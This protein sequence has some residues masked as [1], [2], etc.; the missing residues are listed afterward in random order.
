MILA[1]LNVARTPVM[2]EAPGLRPHALTGDRRGQWS[3]TVSAN[4]RIVFAFE[5]EDVTDVDLVDYH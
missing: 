3:V 2:M 4:W 5:G 1:M